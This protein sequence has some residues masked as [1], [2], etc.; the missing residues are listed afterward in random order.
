MFKTLN[1]MARTAI[2]R[3]PL[4]PLQALFEPT[5]IC[6]LRCDYCR[7]NEDGSVTHT[8]TEDKHFTLE[9]FKE[10][11]DK[12]NHI[13]CANWI[14]DGEP[15]LNPEWN[16]IIEETSR[17]GVKTSFGTNGTL[18]A[19][20]DVDFW[21]RHK[22]TEVSV[23]LDSPIPELY[24]QMRKGAKFDRVIES[25]KLISGAGIKL[26][27]QIILFNDTAKYMPAFVDLAIKVGARRIALP[28]PHLYDSLERYRSSYPDP[29]N[30]NPPLK[31]AM[32]K[33]NRAGIKWYE[34]WYATTH[35]K[36]C[37]WPFLAPYI[38]IGGIIQPCC[39]MS[40]NDKLDNYDGVTYKIPSTNYVMGNI[41]N[42]D[43][44]KI[45][46][47]RDYRDL[48]ELL[49]RTERPIGTTVTPEE[50]H[51]MKNDKSNGRFSHCLGCLWR[52]SIEC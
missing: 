13:Q 52:W 29:E 5:K 10:A 44:G 33:M 16:E 45:W 37:M 42:D 26:Q 11:M 20:S 46:H 25:C 38:Q 49:I 28:R 51:S 19:K 23:S 31:V 27:L 30:V 8:K 14:G 24:E 3:V 1:S 2:R 6:N 18:V 50:I 41:L 21:K 17:R 35:F 39:F 48:R 43:F 36:R 4:P 9:K 12:L 40:G 47:G 32:D 22:V 34:P 15:L 7:R